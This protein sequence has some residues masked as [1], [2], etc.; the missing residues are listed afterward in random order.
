MDS[1]SK[2]QLKDR[3]RDRKIHRLQFNLD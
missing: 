2:D 1:D 3:L